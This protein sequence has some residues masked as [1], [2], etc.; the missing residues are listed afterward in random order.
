MTAECVTRVHRLN[1]SPGQFLVGCSYQLSPECWARLHIGMLLLV[2]TLSGSYAYTEGNMMRLYN[3]R[4]VSSMSL[5]E[6]REAGC[7]AA[8]TP[9]AFGGHG[10][11]TDAHNA[12][13]NLA[14]LLDEAVRRLESRNKEEV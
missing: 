3:G 12:I 2:Q 8:R 11:P 4:K 6:I 5:Q 10:I 7:E 14:Y 1:V 9:N 13:V